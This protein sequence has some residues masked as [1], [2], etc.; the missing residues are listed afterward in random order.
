[1]RTVRDY[2]LEPGTPQPRRSMWLTIGAVAR[3]LMITAGVILVVGGLA[4]VGYLVL[5]V[6]ALNSWASNK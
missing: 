4:M 3:V 1:M 6:V 2:F 5:V